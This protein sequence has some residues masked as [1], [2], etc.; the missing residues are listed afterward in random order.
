[1]YGLTP[2]FSRRV[3]RYQRVGVSSSVVQQGNVPQ[4]KALGASTA[5]FN[6]SLFI[7][8]CG[9]CDVGFA[10]SRFFRENASQPV[11]VGWFL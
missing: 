7:N 11:K 4:R 3:G 2:Y 1:M 6:A 5:V 9:A 8:P 10:V